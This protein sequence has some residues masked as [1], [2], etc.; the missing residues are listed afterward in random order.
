MSGSR[1]K[2]SLVS[3]CS[4]CQSLSALP[5]RPIEE[6]VEPALARI[7]AED[8]QEIAGYTPGA[9]VAWA[10]IHKYAWMPFGHN[11]ALI[12][13]VV[14][15]DPN[16]HLLQPVG[17]LSDEDLRDLTSALASF[18]REVKLFG[19]TE[20]FVAK[21]PAFVAAFEIKDE[22]NSANYIYRA[23]DLANLT[24]SKYA[25][26]R[27]HIARAAREFDFT[28][29]ELSS[30]DVEEC[31]ALAKSLLDEGAS[32]S[33]RNDLIACTAAM[34]QLGALG[35]RGKVI[36]VD[37]AVA[38]FSL[39]ERQSHDTAVVHFERAR[40]DLP[41]LYQIVNRE[42]ARTMLAEGYAF[43]NREEDLGDPG[44]RR[45][46]RS[47]YPAHLAKSFTLTFKGR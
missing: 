42:T 18:G 25:A 23:T 43:I 26:K 33:F 30:A 8:P 3:P 35:L 32:P 21:N 10:P 46:K 44:L 12:A 41:G 20:R 19:V 36:R 47:Y 16:Q 4:T 6:R 38:A 34:R 29:A 22:P 24:G 1:S 7:L 28:S 5:W 9:L 14:E 11:A 40:R 2:L 27:N 13:C 39:W 31:L 15:P 37:G 45:A 17:E